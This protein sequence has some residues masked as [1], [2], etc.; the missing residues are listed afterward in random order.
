MG[1][2]T[3]S[4][5]TY[6][7]VGNRDD[8][9]DM[10]YN[11]APTDTPILNSI[12][13]AKADAVLHEWQTD[14]LA[15]AS[16]NIV[17]EGDDATTDAATATV[18]LSNSSQISDKV[19]RVTGTQQ[20]VN[21]AG[22]R[23]EMAY[24]IAKRA[25]ELKRDMENDIASNNAEVTGSSGTAREHGGLPAW[26]NTNTSHGAGGSAGSLGN[27]AATNGAQRPFTEDLLQA[28]IKSCW[29]A[30]GDP[31]CIIVGSFNK[32][33]MSAF[34]GNATRYKDANDRKLVAAIDVYDSDFGSL[35]VIP[36]RFSRARDAFLLEKEMLATAYLR[37]FRL[38]DLA[39]TGDTEQKQLLVEYTL[40]MR[41]EAAHGF[42][43][44]L[45]TA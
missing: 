42:I 12:P 16:Q 36:D 24:Q 25:K 22:R 23:D 29:D 8:L 32:Q 2:P 10:I 38:W 39:K 21:K 14:T 45:N 1:V 43:A 5:E 3:S 19:P 6:D 41:N 9:S 7:A 37:E 40:E 17:A 4:Y 13:K 11:I 28:T 18:R 35:E 30:G 20:A 44:D 33:E 34:T 15:S 26:L 27:T 31:D